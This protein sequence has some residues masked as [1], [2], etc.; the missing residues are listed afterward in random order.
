[1]YLYLVARTINK[2]NKHICQ[3]SEIITKD[4]RPLLERSWQDAYT[5]G[6]CFCRSNIQCITQQNFP[7]NDDTKKDPAPLDCPFQED[8]N[9][10]LDMFVA[11]FVC[12]QID[13]LCSCFLRPIQL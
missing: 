8:S 1:M 3:Q 7:E 5:G 12:S 4:S 10:G 6:G 9:S 2:H 13:L 11:I